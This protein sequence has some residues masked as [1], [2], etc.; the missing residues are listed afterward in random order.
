MGF[1]SE[2][3]ADDPYIL[4]LT[5]DL[6]RVNLKGSKCVTVC[7]AKECDRRLPSQKQSKG[8]H[9]NNMNQSRTLYVPA[10]AGYVTESD[11]MPLFEELVELFVE[12]EQQQ[13]IVVDGTRY[14]NVFI[15]VLIVADMMFLHKFT[16]RGGCCASTTNFCMFCSCRSKFRHQGE[17]GGCDSCR[18][19][20][21]VYDTNGVFAMTW[22]LPKKRLGNY[23]DRCS[24]RDY[25]EVICR[26][27]KNL[28]G[29]I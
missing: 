4:V 10:V 16:G 7:G 3:T 26:F 9:E 12:I 28:Y 11:L 8:G 23:N 18:R 22:L 5:G 15:K 14:E 25:S 21:K 17:P 29:K 6:A 1:T 20:G 13:C 19:D 2:L 24:W 27:A